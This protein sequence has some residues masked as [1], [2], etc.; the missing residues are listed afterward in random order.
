ME[1]NKGNYEKALEF[2]NKAYSTN[3]NDGGITVLY[4]AFLRR[5]GERE[6]A[7]AL[8]NKLLGFDP[9]NFSAIYEKELL[10]GNS[11]LTKWHNNM[12]DIDNNYLDIALN[13]VKA[14]LFDDAIN[15][16]SSLENPKNPL[17]FYYLAWLYANNNK[18]SNAN[19]MLASA[20]RVSFNYCFPFR[21]ET[22]KVLQYAIDND[23]QNAV[24]YY[25]LGNLLYD[26]RPDDAMKA[27]AMAVKVKSDFPMVWRNLAFGAFYHENDIRKFNRIHEKG[28][29]GRLLVILS[30]ILSLRITMIC[31]SLILENVSLSWKK[32]LIL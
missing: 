4:S 10:K 26:Q 22:E 31:P 3:N 24:A 25:L 2:V 17:V 27:W 16:L 12:Q 1:S 28:D 5:H 32:I 21:Q 19:E 13:Y 14:G 9:L 23:S 29:S 7:L 15:I 11:S 30:G 8:V 18:P 6:K 20:S